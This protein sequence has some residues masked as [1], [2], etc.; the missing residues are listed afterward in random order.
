MSFF[1]VNFKKW[2]SMMEIL[3]IYNNNVAAV[4]TEEKNEMIVS[5]RGICFQKKRGDMIEA[6]KIEKC[7]VLQDKQVISKVE[8]LLQNISSV[9]LDLAHDIVNMIKENSDLDLSENIYI[10]LI[11]HISLFMEREKKNITFENPLL[12]DIKQFYQKEYNLANKAR[13]IIEGYFDIRVSDDEVGFLTLHIVNA[14]MNQSFDITMRAPRLIQVILEIIRVHYNIEFDDN[15]IRYIRFLRH[16]QFFVKRV[17]DERS[18]QEDDTFLYDMNKKAYP[19]AMDCV[20][21]IALF[22]EI[23]YKEKVTKAEKGYLAYH[24]V[25]IVRE[26]K[27][28]DYLNNK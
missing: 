15:S 11:D 9:Y 5:G 8:E 1:R 10:T 26:L 12:L 20:N 3:R 16:L 17:L 22:I 14:S 24:I 21:K 23:N 6:D 18:I 4:L 13:N 19:D 28:D 27:T 25:N 2:G 7:F